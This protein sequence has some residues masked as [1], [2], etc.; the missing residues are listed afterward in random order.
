[1]LR[2][3]RDASHAMQIVCVD[4]FPSDYLKRESAA[5]SIQLLAEPAQTV[6]LN[7]LT[8]VGDGDLLFIDSTHT[9]KVGSEVNRLIFEVLPRLRAGAMVHF[10]DILFPYDY[11][12]VILNTLFF[13][14]ESSLLYAF[15]LNNSKYRIAASLSMLHYARS[16][17][18]QELLPHYKAAANDHGLEIAGK[19]ADGGDFPSSI[20]LSVVQ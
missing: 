4:P 1:M 9:I 14:R 16:A 3:A 15:L 11:G 13:G 7:V 5:G 17:Q 8:D 10:H 6:D 20:Y 19:Q 2:A 18:L 12:R